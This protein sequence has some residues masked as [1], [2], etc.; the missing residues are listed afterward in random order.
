MFWSV[1]N[2]FLPV[3]WWCCLQQHWN[4]S[5]HRYQIL[6]PA[7]SKW[8]RL[9][10]RGN[11]TGRY[12]NSYT[13]IIVSQSNSNVSRETLLP[14][15][16]SGYMTFKLYKWIILIMSGRPLWHLLQPINYKPWNVKE[17]WKCF[18]VVNPLLPRVPFWP[19]FPGFR[20]SQPPPSGSALRSS[21]RQW[22]C[23]CLTLS[24]VQWSAV[25]CCTMHN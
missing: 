24:T 10:Q 8:N 13:I 22:P 23:G 4:R 12:E 3:T 11:T 16:V 20:L 6:V 14:V 21:G 7:V 2:N 17:C 9:S 25:E 5:S 1:H 18:D 19:S 15:L